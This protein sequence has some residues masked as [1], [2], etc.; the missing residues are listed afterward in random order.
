MK[1][2]TTDIDGLT[3]VRIL[4]LARRASVS[5]FCSITHLAGGGWDNHAACGIYFGESDGTLLTISSFVVLVMVRR[6]SFADASQTKQILWAAPG[7]VEC[8][9]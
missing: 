5:Y 2:S 6:L 7:V 3:L 8:G 9:P 4:V 1:L